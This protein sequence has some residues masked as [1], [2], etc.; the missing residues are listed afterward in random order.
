MPDRN[1]SRRTFI[2]EQSLIG[3]GVVMSPAAFYPLT[4]KEETIRFISPVDGDI[5]HI[6]DG[7]VKGGSLRTTVTVNAP[8]N[9]KISINGIK[10]PGN[11]NV[12]TAEVQL[13]ALTNN[14]EV[15][16]SRSG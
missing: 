8:E 9:S 14:I 1:Y 16:D 6:H 3:L 5:L 12:Y 7:V 2:R 10:A 13:S 4:G 15:K 11:K